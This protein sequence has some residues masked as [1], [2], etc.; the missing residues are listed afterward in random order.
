MK[1]WVSLTRKLEPSLVSLIIKYDSLTSPSS[2]WAPHPHCHGDS[3]G[4]SGRRRR[5]RSCPPRASP[6]AEGPAA[7][8][9]QR[10]DN[11]TQPY[12]SENT[13][14]I[15]WKGNEM[16]PTSSAQRAWMSCFRTPLIGLFSARSSSIFFSSINTFPSVPW[17]SERCVENQ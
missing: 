1:R 14:L 13:R 7:G 15:W 17:W 16:N 10:Q 6:S 4:W 5:R 11:G 12:C 9:D 3:T 2:G 8:S